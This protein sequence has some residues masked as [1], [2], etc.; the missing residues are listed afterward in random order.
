MLWSCCNSNTSELRKAF[1]SWNRCIGFS[2]WCGAFSTSGPG[3]RLH[4]CAF[5]PQKL[6][7]SEGNYKT[8]R[9]NCLSLMKPLQPGTIILKVCSLCYS[10]SLTIKTKSAYNQSP[11][12]MTDPLGSFLLP[13]PTPNHR[14][15]ILWRTNCVC[16]EPKAPPSTMSFHCQPCFFIFLSTLHAEL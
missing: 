1:Y 16:K 10:F 12:I 4:P 5:L 11:N 9:R 14:T 6:T 2:R 13:F 3:S 8:V 7:P 15:G